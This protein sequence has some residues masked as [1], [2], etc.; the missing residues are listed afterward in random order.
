MTDFEE[1]QT[2]TNQNCSCFW[3]QDLRKIYL[4]DKKVRIEFLI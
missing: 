3:C 2:F 4:F 1:I